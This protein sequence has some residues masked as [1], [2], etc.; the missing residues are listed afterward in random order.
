MLSPELRIALVLTV[1]TVPVMAM[2]KDP[3]RPPVNPVV[4]EQTVQKK[5]L[6]LTLVLRQDHQWSA[7]INEKLVTIDD[8]VDDARV[9]L[10]NENSVVLS[11]A[12]ERIELR[13]PLGDVRTN[14]VR[15]E[16]F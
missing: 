15:H 13:L 8:E 4:V 1:A 3:M 12:G 5:P 16:V 11:R 6:T 9:T 14:E 7:I 10:I 2:E